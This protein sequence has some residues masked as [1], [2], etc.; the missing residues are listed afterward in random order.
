MSQRTTG[1][2]ERITLKPMGEVFLDPASI[3]RF[4]SGY[5]E[6]FGAINDDDPL[7]EAISAGRK[8]P[9]MEHWLPLFHDRL[10][11]VFDYL[12]D[13][14][15]TLDHQL[16]QARDQRLAQIADFYEA[17]LTHQAAREASRQGRA[18]P[19]AAARSRCISTW[20]NGMP[21]LAGRPVRQ[22]LALRPA[23]GRRRCRRPPRP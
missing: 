13:A 15:V 19:A 6:L 23:G 14:S 5:R 1:E 17:R 20:R 16:E 4:R 10:D 7:Y 22:F 9:G 3:A 18:L 11:T 2:V 12:P 21:A 8:Q